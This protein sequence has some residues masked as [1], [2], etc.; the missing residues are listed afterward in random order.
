MIA[1]EYKADYE[2]HLKKNLDTRLKKYKG[3]EER[4]KGYE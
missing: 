4:Q 3:I 1:N 2:A